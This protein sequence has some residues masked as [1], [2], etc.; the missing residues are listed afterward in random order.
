MEYMSRMTINITIVSLFRLKINMG[1]KSDTYACMVLGN[2]P[3]YGFAVKCYSP[4]G[5]TVKWA[6]EKVLKCPSF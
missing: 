3:M 4:T 6:Q 1:I 5:V 2:N